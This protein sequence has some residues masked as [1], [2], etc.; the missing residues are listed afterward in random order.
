MAPTLPDPIPLFVFVFSLF[1]YPCLPL[2]YCRVF[3]CDL[4]FSLSLEGEGGVRFEGVG[5]QPRPRRDPRTT[6]LRY[7]VF[8]KCIGLLRTHVSATCLFCCHLVSAWFCA[9]LY[10]TLRTAKCWD[11]TFGVLISCW[12]CCSLLRFRGRFPQWRGTCTPRYCGPPG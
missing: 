9:V 1:P 4:G 8:G 7:C 11:T 2:P 5:A 12:D 10:A 6:F 3:V